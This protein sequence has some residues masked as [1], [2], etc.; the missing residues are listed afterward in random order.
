[1]FHNND[2]GNSPA[3]FQKCMEIV[4]HIF[5]VYLCIFIDTRH[6]SIVFMVRVHIV[7]IYL[8]YVMMFEIFVSSLFL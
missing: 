3:G 4:K 6:P 1:M 5:I 2:P 7:I 8:S